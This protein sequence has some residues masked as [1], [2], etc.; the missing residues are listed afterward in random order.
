MSASL[1]APLEREWLA[2]ALETLIAAR[3]E[4]AFL[5]APLLLPEDRFFPDRFTPDAAGVSALAKRLL[6]YANLSH[7]GVRIDTFEN[8]QE[9]A[10]L[11]LDGK[12]AKWSHQGA[13]AWF[14][15]IER[16][17][18]R[19][20]VETGKLTD[21]L[22][23]VAAMAHEVGHAFRHAHRIVRPERDIEEKL[24]DVT[25][26]YLGFGVLTTAAAQR[27]VAQSHGDL[28]SSYSHQQQGYLAGYEMAYLLAMQLAMRGS[29]DRFVAHVAKRLPSN[30]ASALRAAL[31][32]MNRA[33]TADMLG[34]DALPAPQPSPLPAPTT[35]WKRLLG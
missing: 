21:A 12:A 7:L 6:G 2:A 30:Q 24:T 9:I 15:G 3:G 1:P 20:G 29:D 28:G 16:G 35:W 27:Y 17:T 11:G 26:V 33:H 19:F 13:A 34:F 4:E 31:R 18:C 32:E 14:A 5:T 25:T 8:E 23:L 10:E 22:G